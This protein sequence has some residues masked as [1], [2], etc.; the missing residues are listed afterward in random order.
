MKILL[1]GIGGI[2]GYIGSKLL[3]LPRN[4]KAQIY[5]LQRG[6][7]YEQIRKNGLHYIFKTEKTIYPDS[8]F[9]NASTIPIMDFILFSVKS[10]DLESSAQSLANA[11][12]TNTIIA[13]VLNGVNNAERL[14]KL[15][16]NNIVLNGCIYISAFIENAGTVIQKGSA[17]NMILDGKKLHK[18]ELITL[19]DI[20]TNA[21]IKFIFSDNITLD[22]W[23]KYIFISSLATITAANNATIGEIGNNNTLL[24][25]WKELM[26]EILQLAQKKKTGLT[27]K[28]I[29][30]STER[31]KLIPYTTKTSMHIDIENRKY[32]EIDIFTKYVIDECK[33]YQ[34]KHTKH[35][36]YF[37]KISQML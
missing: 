13:T 19:T 16:P 18:N 23:K 37:E 32:P 9:N 14:H 12:G 3:S 27:N 17:G 20:F 2:G 4:K 31:L 22:V 6:E 28:D 7:H 11:I 10:K 35:T 33:T 15:Y 34:L 8:I 25:H 26:N 24:Q 1:V 5:F 36:E 29:L 30:E 21:G